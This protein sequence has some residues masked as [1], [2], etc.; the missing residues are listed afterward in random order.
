MK[1]LAVAVLGNRN[2]GKSYTWNMLFGR[3]VRTG[4]HLHRLQLTP[5]E[6]V[7]V[8]LVSGSPEERKLYVGEII[9]SQQPQIVLCSMQYRADVA[10]TI[11]YFSANDY[12]LYVQWLNPGYSDPS[13]MSDSLS[14]IPYLLNRTAVV[15]MRNG[16]ANPAER[17]QEILDFIYGWAHSRGLLRI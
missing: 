11:D 10:K 7:E 2:A 1:Y 3:T 16:K 8:F 12:S 14:L 15:G 4:K 13:T 9:Q 17:V 6:W 5:T